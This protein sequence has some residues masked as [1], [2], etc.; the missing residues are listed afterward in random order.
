MFLTAALHDPVMS[1]LSHDDFFLDIDPSKAVIRFPLD[2]RIRRF[3]NDEHSPTYAANVEKYRNVVTSK[4]V[5]IGM[6]FIEGTY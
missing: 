3:G 5:S 4:L 1:L 6:K 2:E